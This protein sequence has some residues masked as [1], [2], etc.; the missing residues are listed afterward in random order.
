MFYCSYS[1]S[2]RLIFTFSFL[3]SSCSVLLLLKMFS[4]SSNAVLCQECVLLY[5]HLFAFSP[6]SQEFAVTV[7]F[8]LEPPVLYFPT[9]SKAN[10]HGVGSDCYMMSR[11]SSLPH[12]ST[13]MS[14][15]VCTK[16]RNLLGEQGYSRAGGERGMTHSL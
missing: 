12:L 16:M 15:S 5:V 7:S 1:N 14:G 8:H 3:Y 6:L 13:R 2:F 4:A 11:K 9:H 10:V